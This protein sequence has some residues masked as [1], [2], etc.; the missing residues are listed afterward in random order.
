MKCFITVKKWIPIV[1]FEWYFF[2]LERC[3]LSVTNS[4]HNINSYTYMNII[5]FILCV[6][7]LVSNIVTQ[8]LL[9]DASEKYLENPSRWFYWFRTILIVSVIS[10]V[11]NQVNT[12]TACRPIEILYDL[13]HILMIIVQ[14]HGFSICLAFSF[15]LGVK[16]ASVKSSR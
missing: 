11:C 6:V 5:N 1:F 16:F 13:R 14:L 10:Y 2:F 7:F 8:A 9:N 12:I 15:F 3:F 4:I